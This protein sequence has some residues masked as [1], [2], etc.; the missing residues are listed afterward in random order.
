MVHNQYGVSNLI[1]CE[2]G[3]TFTIVNRLQVSK[4]CWRL[5]TSSLRHYTCRTP[6]HMKAMH[7]HVCTRR[8]TS[9]DAYNLTTLLGR[10]SN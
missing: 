3:V 5:F 7:I 10:I 1:D 4:T 9:R 6:L 8:H 2:R